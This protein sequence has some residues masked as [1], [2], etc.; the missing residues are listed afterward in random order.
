MA[1]SIVFKDWCIV[2]TFTQIYSCLSY[3][4]MRTCCISLDT[5][6]SLIIEK[7]NHKI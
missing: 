5:Y 3:T 1:Y 2:Y 7:E 4:E 6:I